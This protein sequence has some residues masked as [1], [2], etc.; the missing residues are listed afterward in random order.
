M[1]VGWGS[2]IVQFVKSGITWASY[3][4]EHP[5]TINILC[6]SLPLV[7]IRYQTDKEDTEWEPVKVQTH[8]RGTQT[9]IS[10]SCKDQ[11]QNWHTHKLLSK[12]I[13]II[14]WCNQHQTQITTYLTIDSIM[15]NVCRE[16]N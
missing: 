7:N 3:K 2:V 13:T 1:Y 10:N 16:C 8:R 15:L 14:A 12:Y 4:L 5:Q 9:T 11:T 6:F